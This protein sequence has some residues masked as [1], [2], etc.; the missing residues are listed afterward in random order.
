M[1]LSKSDAEVWA[2]IEASS[3]QPVQPVVKTGPFAGINEG[4]QSLQKGVLPKSNL[5][6]KKTNKAKAKRKTKG[7]GCK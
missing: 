1:V 7:C 3:N 2:Q 5:R 6:K 4:F